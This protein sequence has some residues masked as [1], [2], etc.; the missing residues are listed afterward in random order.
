MSDKETSDA[1]KEQKECKIHPLGDEYPDRFKVNSATDIDNFYGPD[2]LY[3]QAADSHVYLG[4]AMNRR[5]M[6]YETQAHCCDMLGKYICFV[7]NGL[8][9][10]IKRINGFKKKTRTITFDEGS[11]LVLRCEQAKAYCKLMKNW[12]NQKADSKAEVNL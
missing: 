7:A 9:L 3:I 10:N 6:V 1:Q 12:D 8:S 5:L 2:L 11:T 4:I